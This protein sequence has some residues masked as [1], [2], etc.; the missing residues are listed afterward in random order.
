MRKTLIGAAVAVTTLGVGGVALASGTLQYR[1]T[2]TGA[3]EVPTAVDTMAEADLKVKVNPDRTE[4]RYDLTITSPIENVFMAHL[5]LGERGANGPV[6]VWL[7]PHPGPPTQLIA[8][9]FEGRL[10]K[11]VITADDLCWTAGALYCPSGTPMWDE[12]LADLEAGNLYLNVHTTQNPPGEVRG[13]VER[14]HQHGL[15]A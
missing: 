8:G 14:H 5:H 9:S 4:V 13:Q 10:A 1:T 12:F 7:Y 6:G 3:E 15:D 2:G 11:D